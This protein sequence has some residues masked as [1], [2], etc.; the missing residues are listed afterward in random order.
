MLS[1]CDKF[2]VRK[3]NKTVSKKY[4]GNI[5]SAQ[6]EKKKFQDIAS[7][8]I[9]ASLNIMEL[10]CMPRGQVTSIPSFRCQEQQ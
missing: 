8:E 4:A 5:Y 7:T 9:T 10:S 6:N 2:L 1:H 3:N